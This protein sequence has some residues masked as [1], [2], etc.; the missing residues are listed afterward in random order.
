MMLKRNTDNIYLLEI[1]IAQ[2]LDL[3]YLGNSTNSTL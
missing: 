1:G 2:D 3:N